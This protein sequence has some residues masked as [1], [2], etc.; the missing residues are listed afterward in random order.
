[1]SEQINN[2][3]KRV[4]IKEEK[5]GLNVQDIILVAVLLA[6]GAVLKFFVGTII[7]IGGMKPNFI[8]AMYCLA[9][10]LIKPKLHEAG[11]IGILAGAICQFFPGTALIN[12][13]SEILGALSMYFFTRLSFMK[14][15]KFDIRPIIGSFVSTVI[16]G[17]MYVVL[18]F[19][20]TNAE[21]SAMIA[22]IPI[23]I[24]T[25]AI[26]CIIVQLLYLPVKAA[27]KKD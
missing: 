25:A 19:I 22:Y 23:V 3:E 26:N 17:G 7:N 5:K 16:S 20:V 6:A 11:I 2:I 14:I 24:C 8:I 15:K 27:L 4:L 9:I 18:L 12:L 13:G 21:K 10:M 1:M